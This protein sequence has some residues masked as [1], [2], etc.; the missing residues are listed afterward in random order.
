MTGSTGYLIR[1]SKVDIFKNEYNLVFR[2]FESSQNAA[3][4]VLQ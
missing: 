1:A 2:R 4:N 3:I